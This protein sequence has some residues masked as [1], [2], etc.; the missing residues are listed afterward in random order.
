MTPSKKTKIISI[1]PHGPAYHFSPDAMPDVFWKKPD[2]SVVGFWAHE[3]LDVLGEAVLKETGRYDWE[4]WQ[5]DHRADRVY[6]KTLP[7]G[8]THKLF[9]AEDKLYRV[10]IRS[11]IGIFSGIMIERL[12]EL[13]GCPLVLMLY[14]TY[15]FR[16][17]FYHEILKTFG[18]SRF[19]IFLRSGGM[20]KTPLGEILKLHRP[21]TYLSLIIEHLE[22]KKLFWHVDV[23]SE[24]SEAALREV[25]RIYGG[26]IEKLTMGCDFGFWTPAPT[27][28]VKESARKKL[29][30]PQGKTVFFASGNFVPRKQ[31]DRLIEVFRSIETRN[32]FFLIVAGQGD[33]PSTGM[34]ASLAEPLI[35]QKKAMLHPYAVGEELRDLY[36]ASDIYASV[37]TDEGGPASVMKAMACGLP[38][39]STPVGETAARM[40]EYGAGR[41]VPVKN[42]KE[43]VKAILEILDKKIP[44]ALDIKIAR[45][46]YDWPN[47]AKR[48]I[49]I[50]DDL[51]S[52]HYGTKY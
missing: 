29:N 40:K 9:P 48:F 31:F 18:R 34:L 43:W 11:Q 4:V 50:Y 6:S 27:D 19:P 2:G 33:E 13:Q 16:V 23:I 38:V 36:R 17:P 47:V 52:A 45:D 42:Y 3:W 46:V 24:Q 22:L 25:K 32:D 41:F 30:I 7:T 39:L 15:G 10:G 12:K 28:G 21:L 49:S 8:V 5:P 20:F 35:K 26:R 37:A 51:I 44:R 14:G 1:M